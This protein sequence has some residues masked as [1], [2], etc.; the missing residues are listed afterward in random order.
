MRR[1]T[2]PI[3]SYRRRPVSRVESW[4]PACA[5]V[6]D[7][8]SSDLRQI[9]RGAREQLLR[10]DTPRRESLLVVI[11]QECLEHVAVRLEAVAPVVLAHQPARGLEFRDAPRETREEMSDLP[12][13]VHRELFRAEER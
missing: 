10:R 9:E 2:A 13:L 3:P 1:R 5:G 4:T 6:T 11:A 7:S 8:H 12:E